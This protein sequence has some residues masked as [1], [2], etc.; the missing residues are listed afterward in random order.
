LE[1]AAWRTWVKS[2]YQL[3]TISPETLNW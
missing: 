2:K 1:N 3:P